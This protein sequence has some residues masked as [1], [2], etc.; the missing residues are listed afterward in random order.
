MAEGA[1]HKD[2]LEDPLVESP[3]AVVAL[4]DLGRRVEEELIGSVAD[5][6]LDGGGEPAEDLADGG[7]A[8]QGLEE[9]AERDLVQGDLDGAGG[10]E[11]SGGRALGLVAV[12]GEALPFAG[13]DV[14]VPQPFMV[15]WDRAPIPRSKIVS[16]YVAP[17]N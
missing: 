9:F 6:A 2:I 11:V 15:I 14:I 5:A 3:L 10:R 4:K 17:T 1:A 12:D 7:L 13:L 8:G 16:D